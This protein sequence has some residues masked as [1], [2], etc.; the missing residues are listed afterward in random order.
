VLVLA[1]APEPVML[2]GEVCELEVERERPQHV[3]LPIEGQ[4]GDR[5]GELVPRSRTAGR[6]RVAGQ[7]ADSLLGGEEA[8]TT[9]LDEH[10]SEGLAEQA[11]VPSERRVGAGNGHGRLVSCTTARAG[12]Q[13]RV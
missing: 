2:L 12:V 5:F 13:T 11:H 6:T 7:L 4:C 10:A 3:G 8:R 9:L 1:S